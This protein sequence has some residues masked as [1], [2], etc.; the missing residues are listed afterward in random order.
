M[1]W[2]KRFQ[3]CLPVV[4]IAVE[5][6]KFDMQKMRDTAISGKEYQQG[7]LFQYEVTEYLL[8]KF[9][10]QCAYCGATD[11][12]LQKEHIVPKALGG[13]NTISNLAIACIPCN[14]KKAAL[15]IE[16]FL[17]INLKYSKELKHN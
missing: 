8:E 6:V 13:T 4:S 1:S 9:N 15:S 3:R 2:V 5:R 11:C 10:H 16:I 12:K 14:Q 7:T 17:K